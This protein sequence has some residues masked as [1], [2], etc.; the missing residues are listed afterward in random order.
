MAC[1]SELLPDPGGGP[2]YIMH[3]GRTPQSSASHELVES[4]VVRD[5]YL[6]DK[7]TSLMNEYPL[8]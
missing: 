8:C 6:G 3:A 1:L 4:E 7:F 2:S 5:L